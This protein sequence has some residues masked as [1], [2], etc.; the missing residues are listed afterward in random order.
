MFMAS[1]YASKEKVGSNDGVTNEGVQV[2]E[3]A[4]DP[5]LLKRCCR[6]AKNSQTQ[7]MYEGTM[8]VGYEVKK[9]RVGIMQ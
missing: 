7:V 2:I 1:K 5:L 9:K 8:L 4:G 6:I 3:I